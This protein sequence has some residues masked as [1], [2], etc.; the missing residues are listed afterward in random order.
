MCKPAS[1][2]VTKNRVYWSKVSNGHENIISENNLQHLDKEDFVDLLRVEI[3]P[4]GGDFT[5]K[6]SLWTYKVDQDFRPK[7]Y[8]PKDTE[9]RVR[10]ALKDWRKWWYATQ[11]GG[12]KVLQIAGH[13]SNQTAGRN[14]NQ[15]ACHYSNQT[16]GNESNQIAGNES[17]QIAGYNSTQTAG[18][19]SNQTAGHNSNQTACHYSNQTAGNESNQIAGNESNQ[20]AGYNSTQT[21]GEGTLQIIRYYHNGWKCFTRIVTKEQANKKYKFSGSIWI[22]VIL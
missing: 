5:L 14:S 17:N 19:E 15:T 4:L 3:T 6:Q 7:W 13:N 22:E 20:I 1:F 8:Q 9:R 2:V 18:N 10:R 12:D 16:A 11:E 21:A